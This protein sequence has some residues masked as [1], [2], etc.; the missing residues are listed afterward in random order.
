M[1]A[2]AKEK[3]AMKLQKVIFQ[4][5]QKLLTDNLHERLLVQSI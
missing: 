3:N 4:K 1:V 2:F 5:S